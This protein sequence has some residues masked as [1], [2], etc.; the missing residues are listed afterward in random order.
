MGGS[1]VNGRTRLACLAGLLWVLSSVGACGP[2]D[3]THSQSWQ[4]E[5]AVEEM[6]RS[7]HRTG[8]VSAPPAVNEAR[9]P[10]AQPKTTESTKQYDE[11][12]PSRW[13]RKLKAAYA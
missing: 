12:H 4:F 3:S 6:A 5:R 9:P 2:V 1:T 11:R 8:T 7:A 13:K 10:A